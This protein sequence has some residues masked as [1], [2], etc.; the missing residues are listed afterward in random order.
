MESRVEGGRVEIGQQSQGQKMTQ[1]D[2]YGG[3]QVAQVAGATWREKDIQAE[4][5]KKD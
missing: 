3:L 4:A 5:R 1:H 2:E